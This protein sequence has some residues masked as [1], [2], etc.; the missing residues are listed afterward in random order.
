[1]ASW[2]KFRTLPLTGDE[3][4]KIEKNTAPYLK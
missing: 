4:R 3:F 1:M 2:K